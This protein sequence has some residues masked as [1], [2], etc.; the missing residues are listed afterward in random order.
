M[1]WKQKLNNLTNG[2]KHAIDFSV[3][4]WNRCPEFGKPDQLIQ[5]FD[6]DKW[7]SQKYQGK[8][9]QVSVIT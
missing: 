5:N 6:V 2:I 9:M 7:T 8:S 4:E 1:N 3:R